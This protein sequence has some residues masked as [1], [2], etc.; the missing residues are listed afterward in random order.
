MGV[1]RDVRYAFVLL[2][3]SDGTFTFVSETIENAEDEYGYVSRESGR[4]V[5][6]IRRIRLLFSGLLEVTHTRA[7]DD[8]LGERIEEYVMSWLGDHALDGF[9]DYSAD[10]YRR[11]Y[12]GRSPETGWEAIVMSWQE[13]NRTSIHAHPQFA[14][15]FFADGRFLVEIFEPAA[16]G[17]ARLQ[18]SVVVEA[19]LGFYAVGAEGSFENH[20]HRITCL[21]PTGHSLHVYS[22]DALRGTVY[23]ETMQ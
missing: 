14:G 4:P 13:G 20:I 6:R 10:G 8:G 21:S 3:F 23:R 19:P 15:Y 9:D 5:A 22:D 16:A 12:L 17:Y 7:V 1:K 2:S 18:R 11:T